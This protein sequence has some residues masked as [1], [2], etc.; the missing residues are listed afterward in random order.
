MA[1]LN[2]VATRQRAAAV[3]GSVFEGTKAAFVERLDKVPFA[4]ALSDDGRIVSV[5]VFDIAP[6]THACKSWGEILFHGTDPGYQGRGYGTATLVAALHY[7]EEHAD[8]HEFGL[9]ADT[10]H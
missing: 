8:H 5:C 9:F 1:N 7:F 3:L 2:T 6:A 10:L 4:V